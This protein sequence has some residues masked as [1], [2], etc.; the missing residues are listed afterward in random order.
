M[1]GT[2]AWSQVASDFFYY[3]ALF[4]TPHPHLCVSLMSA[5]PSSFIPAFLQMTW[6]HHDTVFQWSQ[7]AVNSFRA[8]DF[9]MSDPPV[10]VDGDPT[11]H[12]HKTA[13]SSEPPGC[14][15]PMSSVTVLVSSCSCTHLALH[16]PLS[17]SCPIPIPFACTSR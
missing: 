11:R 17:S 16:H 7:L 4:T 10:L 2:P 6:P 15:A 3:S 9:K 12:Q 1:T 8:T 13:A 5:A 14:T